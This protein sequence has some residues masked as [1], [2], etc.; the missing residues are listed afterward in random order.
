MIDNSEELN[1][2][3][4]YLLTEDLV[5][6]KIGIGLGLSKGMSFTE[7]SELILDE[8]IFKIV[9]NRR[10]EL[11]SQLG[12]DIVDDLIVPDD[13]KNEFLKYLTKQIERIH[14]TEMTPPK[15]KF[16]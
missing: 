5:D 7:L 14:K 16:N 2:I 1:R 10:V 3:K 15:K 13:L 11:N 6:N 4:D 9:E 8:E 12:V